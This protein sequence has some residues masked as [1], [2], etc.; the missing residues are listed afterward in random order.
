M[1]EHTLSSDKTLTSYRVIAKLGAEALDSEWDEEKD[2][3]DSKEGKDG[4]EDE[5]SE[6]VEEGK[7]RTKGS[8]TEGVDVNS[9][10]QQPGV[11]HAVS[12]VNGE[13]AVGRHKKHVLGAHIWKLMLD[14]CAFSQAQ[15]AKQIEPQFN[16]SG[17]PMYIVDGV[18]VPHLNRP[19]KLEWEAWGTKLVKLARDL[20]CMDMTEQDILL[21]A[22]IKEIQQAVRTRVWLMMKAE[23]HKKALHSS[24][25]DV[26][27]F[28]AVVDP[29]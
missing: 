2:S 19:F 11:S 8:N 17:K 9:E 22:S 23:N 1:G 27:S 20:K 16:D 21:S 7:E 6:G 26:V 3:E 24:G 15:D 13:D 29:Y 5:D 28:E 25:L 18:L 4:K 14:I 12:E 10:S